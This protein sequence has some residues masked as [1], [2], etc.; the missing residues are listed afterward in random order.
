MRVMEEADLWAR[1]ARILAERRIG[2][3]RALSWRGR[4][5]FWAWARWPRVTR[6]FC[7]PALRR[8]GLWGTK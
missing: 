5:L 2:F 8:T 6:L 3:H 7:R 4:L 1:Q